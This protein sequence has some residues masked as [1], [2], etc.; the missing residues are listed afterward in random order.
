LAMRIDFLRDLF[1]TLGMLAIILPCCQ[2]QSTPIEE[3]KVKLK[4]TL[5]KI[6]S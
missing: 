4:I 5:I 3:I 6:G 1:T 2:I